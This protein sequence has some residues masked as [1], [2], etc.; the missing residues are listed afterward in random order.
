MRAQH[1]AAIEPRIEADRQEAD[2]TLEA[3]V[4]N[5][6]RLRPGEPAIH[7]AQNCAADSACR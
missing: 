7:P 2:A 4:L 5:D 3:G 6:P 1:R